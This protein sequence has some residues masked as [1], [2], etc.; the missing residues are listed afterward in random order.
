MTNSQTPQTNIQEQFVE[1]AMPV[2]LPWRIMIFSGVILGL[3]IFFAVGLK[4]GY[5]KYLDDQL[6]RI[7]NNINALSSSVKDKQQEYVGFYSQIVNIKSVLEKRSI[8]ANIFPFLETNTIASVYYTEAEMT[9]VSQTLSVKG[10]ARSLN[11]LS[12]QIAI[13][14]KDIKDV[15]NVVLDGVTIQP[16]GVSFSLSIHFT[17][18]FLGNLLK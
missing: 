5:E 8:T 7:T 16:G 10:F 17:N 11:D 18:A 4:L 15:S 3:A 6:S 2:G 1:T 14:E 13:V 12:Q 9:S